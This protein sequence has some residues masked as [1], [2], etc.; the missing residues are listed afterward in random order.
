MIQ[1][2]NMVD[3]FYA[4][5]TL[6]NCKPNMVESLVRE[7]VNKQK[8]VFWSGKNVSVIILPPFHFLIEEYCIFPQDQ[9]RFCYDLVLEYLDCFDGR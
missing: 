3:I 5:K 2:Q 7:S 6:R 4:V 1:Y 9:Y 8:S